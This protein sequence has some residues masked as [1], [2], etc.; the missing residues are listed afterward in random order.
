MLLQLQ[1]IELNRTKLRAEGIEFALERPKKESPPATAADQLFEARRRVGTSCRI[2]EADSTIL[3]DLLALKSKGH[4]RLLAEPRLATI[5]G[6][7]CQFITGGE[8]PVP[9]PAS[10]GTLSIEYK[11]FGT[12]FDAKPVLGDDDTLRLEL[13][14]RLQ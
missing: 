7:P 4:V 5:S 9:V 10:L 6:R 2:E 1:V 11:K 8:F 13:R 12:Q 14:S 3:K